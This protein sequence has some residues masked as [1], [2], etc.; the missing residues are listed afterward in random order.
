MDLAI[1]AGATKL[2]I[3]VVSYNTR[4]M[5]LACLTSIER[6]TRLRNYEVIVVDNASSDGSASAIEKHPLNVRLLSLDENVGFA[7]ANNLGAMY[8]RG[9][10]I[11]LLNPD[12]LVLDGAIDR[13]VSFARNN[14]DCG[15]WGGRTQFAD[16]RLNPSSC[17]RRMSLWSLTC[18][19]TG[20]SKLLPDS[21]LFN[22]EAYGGWDRDTVAEVDIVSGCFFLIDAVLWRK[23]KGFDARFFMYGEE[24]D[25]CLRAEKF[26]A[27]PKITPA[28]RIVHYGGAS[29]RSK[30]GKLVKLLAAKMTLIR[31]HFHPLAKPFG[32]LLLSLWP[33]SRAVL[34]SVSCIVTRLASQRERCESWRGVWGA[35]GAWIR[36][37]GGVGDGLS[38]PIVGQA[39]SLAESSTAR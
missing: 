38:T 9:E 3:I 12:T 17:W 6:E 23:L 1:D 29:E 36:G 15:I 32:I 11:L 16:G 31:R 14:R 21:N 10:F 22:P 28:A 35:K 39:A 30:A 33:L 25:L 7:R 34:F 19:A 18:A 4:E 27:G 26:G 5:T 8:A 2:S 37:Y 20:L 13:I 24:A